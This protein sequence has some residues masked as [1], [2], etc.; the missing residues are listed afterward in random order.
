MAGIALPQQL[1]APIKGTSLWRDAGRR[2]VRNRAAMVGFFLVFMFVFVAFF[3]PLISPYSPTEGT[4]LHRFLP[5]SPSHLLGTD[6]QGRDIL[7]RILWGARSSLWVSVLS[8]T[9]GLSIGLTYGSISGY[10]GGWVDFWMMRVVDIILSLP[11][12]LLT[13]TIVLFLGPG[14]NTIAFAIAIE[15][16]PIFARLVRSS[17]LALK[18]SDFV[19]AAHSIGASNRRILLAHIMPNALTPVIVQGTLALAT[20][21]VD[22][23][24][25]GYLG[26]GP[27]DPA[28]PEWGTMLTDTQRYL[29]SGAAYTALFPGIAIILAVL[30]F[31]LLGDGLR[32]ALDPRLK[33]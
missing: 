1:E 29:T 2:L 31:N 6:L 13:I 26:F 17:I 10:A 22:A 19:L 8:V 16:V 20:A 25:L 24:G 32:E 33:R 15:N 30:G 28:T 11:G 23:A 14:L 21:I 27:Q 3:A 4:I 9:V 18:E 12:L 5:P 7:S